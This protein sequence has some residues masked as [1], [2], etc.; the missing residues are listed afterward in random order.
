MTVTKV[1]KPCVPQITR[2]LRSK[3]VVVGGVLAQQIKNACGITSEQ[4]YLRLENLDRKTKHVKFNEN[5]IITG[6][7]TN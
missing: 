3:D 1:P 5:A 2:Q 4:N 6:E 7:R